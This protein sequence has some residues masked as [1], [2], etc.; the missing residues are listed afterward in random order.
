MEKQTLPN[1]TVIL[2]LGI[3]SI[4]GCCCYGIPGIIF[5]IV[6]IIMANK[7]TTVYNE[8]LELYSHTGLQNV[9]TGK[10]LAIIG[11]VLSI[12][13]F[14]YS[15]FSIFLY[16]ILGIGTIYEIMKQY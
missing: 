1:S 12:L 7:A 3:L 11:L 5:G 16:G 9:K 4:L 8:N 15:I 6:T 2:V 13:Y 10:I 14:I